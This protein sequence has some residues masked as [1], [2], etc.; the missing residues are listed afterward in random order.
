VN[1]ALAL[2]AADWTTAG[3]RRALRRALCALL[4]RLEDED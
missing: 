3:D 2:I 1:A 4:V